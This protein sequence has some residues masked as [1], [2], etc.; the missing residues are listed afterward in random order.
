MEKHDSLCPLY[1]MRPCQNEYCAWWDEEIG[2][3][4]V[5]VSTRWLGKICA[6]LEEANRMERIKQQGGSV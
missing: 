4:C 5:K 2:A 3:C 6:C 1:E